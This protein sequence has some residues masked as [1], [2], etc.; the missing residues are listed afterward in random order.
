MS[1]SMC[2]RVSMRARAYIYIWT[3]KYVVGSKSFRP[4]IQKPRQMEN[5]VKG[6]TVL[7]M[8]KLMYQFETVLK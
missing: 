7:S 2:V 1:D 6:Y 8:A 3:M 5:A 4:D